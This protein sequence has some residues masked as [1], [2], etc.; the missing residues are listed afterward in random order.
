M[1]GIER[2]YIGGYCPPILVLRV[3]VPSPI[4][5]FIADITAK[6][7]VMAH[8]PPISLPR[9]TVPPAILEELLGEI[10]S[11][12]S[13]YHKPADTFIGKTRMGVDAIKKNMFEY[14]S[15]PSPPWILVSWTPTDH[16]SRDEE[17]ARQAAVQKVVAGQQSENL[18]DFD[19][20]PAIEGQPSL[21][22][23]GAAIASNP[24]AAKVLTSSNPL[25]DLVSIFGSTSTP[26][27]TSPAVGGVPGAFG[28]FDAFGGLGSIT[29]AGVQTAAPGVTFVPAAQATASKT[30]A[31]D[32]LL[33]LF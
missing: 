20:A 5:L 31:E 14:A 29:P 30:N 22:G 7:V 13:V 15:C 23:I 25:D 32:D 28:G 24:A 16:A 26:P 4:L 27:V 8:R 3:Y 12:A 21:G 10:G 9:T 11:L 17:T 1:Y 2:I 18:L 6:S 33:G 19:D